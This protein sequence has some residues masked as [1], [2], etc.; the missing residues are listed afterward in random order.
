MGCILEQFSELAEIFFIC[1]QAKHIV[2]K[3]D[4]FVFRGFASFLNDW[5]TDLILV[6]KQKLL[7]RHRCVDWDSKRGNTETPLQTKLRKWTKH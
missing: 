6:I 5:M 7:L 3:I 4:V 1:F 2:D